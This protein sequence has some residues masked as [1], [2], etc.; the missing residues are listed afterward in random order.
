MPAKAS[1]GDIENAVKAYV[2]GESCDNAAARFN[3]SWLTLST[4]L[5]RRDLFR[6]KAD[7]YAIARERGG[8]TRR[9]AL[10]LPDA[11]IAA[12][13]IAG[14]SENALSKAYGVSRN[15][16][17]TRLESSG[18][19]IR[20]MSEAAKLRYVGMTA[21]ERGALMEKAQ[22]ATRGRKQTRE[23]RS[24]IALT[25]QERGFGI[26][27]TERVLTGWLRDRG[28]DVIPQRAIGP[29]NVDL[30]IH[31]VAVEIL[32]GGWHASKPGH[33]KRARYILNRDWCIIYIWVNATRSP[34]LESVT[35]YIVAAVQELRRSPS[36]VRQYRMIR[37][38]GQELARGE[39][40]VEDIAIVVPGYESLNGSPVD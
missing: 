15:A 33:A 35:D 25:R 2:S 13:Y 11:E 6:S 12:R 5:K 3:T 9:K 7:R 16:I 26:S 10:G 1:A 23:H 14:E 40:N 30:A 37:G 27:E 28:L 20:T 29:Y 21:E 31:P 24:K 39:S 19:T 22:E 38:D 32:G 17:R 34:L 4:E 36:P 18:V 8:A